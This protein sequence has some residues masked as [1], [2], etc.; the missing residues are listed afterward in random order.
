MSEQKVRPV[1][2]RRELKLV[3]AAA[4]SI[5]ILG[6]VGASA[7]LGVGAAG[8]LGRAAPWAFIFALVGVGLVSYGFIRLSRSIA[9]AGS[10][11]ALAGVTLGPRFG[12]LGG[13]ALFGAYLGIGVGSTVEIGLFLGNFLRGIGVTHYEGWV[14]FA[15]I[16]LVAMAFLANN[17]IRIITRFLIYAEITAAT[18]AVA[19]SIVILVRL[20]IGDAPGTQTLTLSFLR[21]PAG[22]DFTIIAGAAVFGFLA[23]AGFEGAAVLGEETSNPKREIPRAITIAIVV[24]AI[25]YLLVFISQTLGFGVDAKGVAAFQASSSPFYDLSS[26]YVGAWLGDI[27][28]LAAAISL[29]GIGLAGLAA[30]ARILMALWRDAVSSSGGLATVSKRTG[31]PIVAVVFVAVVYLVA[32]IVEWLLNIPV[33][34]ATFYPLTLGTLSL[35]VAY[36]L[37]NF[38]A[39][40]YLFFMGVKRAATWQIVIPIAG[41]A[42]VI[43]TFYKNAVGLSSPYNVFPWVVAAYIAIAVVIIVAAPRAATR[44]GEGL[45]ASVDQSP[46]EGPEPGTVPPGVNT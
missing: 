32:I 4:L 27:L 44:I 42:F 39:M 2:L 6:P 33:L 41:A 37:V 9:H 19:L 35:L 14:P 12:F 29:F 22:V 8:I 24:V 23:F 28:N 16:G 15:L 43:Y 10:V 7:L 25:F 36:L 5:G 20:A 11:Y 31:S 1:A 46:P 21:L 30:A 40:R 13:W 26:L 38:G 18:I 17:E 45:V 3:D 34:N